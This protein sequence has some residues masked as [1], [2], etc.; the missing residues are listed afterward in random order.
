MKMINALGRGIA[1][2]LASGVMFTAAS[3]EA[4]G[5]FFCN[6]SQ[7]VNQAAERIVFADN[8]DGT[9]TA[10][11]QIQYQGAAQD[12]SWLLPIS[13][14]PAEDQIKLAS[15]LA[16]TRLQSATNPFYQLTTTVEGECRQVD[17]APSAS[18]GGALPPTSTPAPEGPADVSVEASGSVGPFEWT[19]ISVSENSDDPAADAVQWLQDNGYQVPEGSQAL[20]APYLS[21]GLFLLAL[22]LTKDSDVGSIRPIVLT[23]EADRAIIPVKLTAV[24][25]QPDMGVMTWLLG[26]GRGIPENYLS[27]EINEARLNWFN[28]SSNYND[29]IIDAANDAGGQGF[30]TEYAGNPEDLGQVIW[31]DYEEQN[32]QSFSTMTFSSFDQIFQYA[33]STWG[34]YDGFW[35]AVQQTV[36]FT[37][38]VAFAD[39][40]LCPTCYSDQVQFSPSEFVA[41]LETNVIEPMRTMQQLLDAHPKMTRLYTTLSAEEMTLDPLFTFNPDLEDVSNVHTA[42]RVIECNPNIDQFSAPWRV[43]LPQGGMVRGSGSNLV[44]PDELSTLPPNRVIRRQGTSG[45]GKVIEDNSD[46]ILAALEKY[47]AKLKPEGATGPVK[48]PGDGGVEPGGGSTPTDTPAAT[49]DGGAPAPNGPT[50]KPGPM[51]TKVPPNS[52]KPA[53]TGSSAQQTTDGGTAASETNQAV[54]DDSGDDDGCGI[55]QRPSRSSQIWA[56]ALAAAAVL[57]SKRRRNSQRVTRR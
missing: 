32:W 31:Q 11:I 54:D 27:L 52:G 25:A 29:V 44:W 51:G 36:T 24:A 49:A 37:G 1:L 4:C 47:N 38:S 5:G 35:D 50:T 9:V 14:A 13:T 42:N 12:F 2:A 10:V 33:Y 8:G 40:K 57:L 22:R 45:S 16:F 23:Y 15:N 20:I 19:V 7:P 48:T 6:S 39:F 17:F 56:T 41:A 30:V 55:A 53:P 46:S 3:A 34:T 43:E 18:A 21:D 28:A 26:E